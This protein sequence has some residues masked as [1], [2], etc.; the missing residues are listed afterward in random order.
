MKVTDYIT[1][2]L[3]EKGVNH[4]FGIPGGVVLDIL[5]SLNK[6]KEK[7]EVH[8]NYHEQASAFA[9]CGYAQVTGQIGIAYATKGPGV[10]NLVTGIANAYFD[11]IPVLFLTAHSKEH[12]AG[13]RF[14]EKQEFDTIRMISGIVKY[15]ARINKLHDIRYHLERAHYEAVSGRPGPVFLDIAHAVC[16]A[17]VEPAL[18]RG[19]IN[20]SV[21]IQMS[22]IEKTSEE[23]KAALNRAKRPVLLIGDGIH[24][25][26][27]ESY[28]VE[29]VAKLKIP[30]LS[31]RFAQ[32]IAADS[33]YYF[34]F[35]GSHAMRY[36][37]FILSKCD[38]VISLGNR[39]AYNPESESFGNFTRYCKVIRIDVDSAEFTRNLSNALNYHVDIKQFLPFL[40]KT[41]WRCKTY[42]EWVDVC[43]TL[44]NRLFSYDTEYPVK[45]ISNIIKHLNDGV[46]ITSDV[47]KN[48]LWLAHAYALA[49]RTNRILYSKSLGASGSSLPKAIGVYYATRNR[50]VC[51]TGDVGIQM[52]IQELQF[53]ARDKLPIVIIL[54]NN[55]V[56]GMIRDEQKYKFNSRFVHSTFDSGYAT[57]NFGAVANVFS[58]PYICL[59]G[60]DKT[61]EFKSFLSEN[62]PVFIEIK[63]DEEADVFPNLPKGRPCQEFNFMIA[64]PPPPVSDS[65]GSVVLTK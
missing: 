33:K 28:L 44:K 18:M 8:L 51:F 59:D 10:T 62:G 17:E 22:D 4:V 20:E 39:L 2:F 38:L 57:P 16:K 55:Q 32:D 11:S 54:L 65:S 7:I 6:Q 24:Q 31:S 50:V 30:V 40:V 5:D 43:M 29:L 25:S 19:F 53:I 1:D 45:I 13:L 64:P 49:G 48:E 52:N 15:A 21:G 27:T 12:R 3:I 14:E 34:G 46:V 9:A 63:I 26:G 35:I 56:S 58:I 60:F 42:H 23:I 41:P 36:S 61:F 37:N 47:G